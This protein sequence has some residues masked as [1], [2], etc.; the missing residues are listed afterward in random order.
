M[1]IVVKGDFVEIEFTGIAN[2][3]VFDT[4]NAEELKKVNPNAIPKKTIIAIG[5]GMVVAGLDF[6]LD[7]KEIG[8]EYDILIKSNDAFGPRKK[9]L[10]KV[11]PLKAFTEKEVYPQAGMVLTLD[12]MLVKIIAVSGARVTVDFNNP[13]AGKDLNYK[14]KI[15][16][17]VESDEEKSKAVFELMFRFVPEFSTGEKI[18]VK[19]PKIME[20]FVKAYGTKFKEIVGK[21]LTFE[22][23]ETKVDDEK[24]EENGE[25]GNAEEKSD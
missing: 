13:L 6:A 24:K 5:H 8:K 11:I 19:G 3:E 14:F 12:D 23:K 17:K 22:L 9:E 16:R 1:T 20:T 15:V 10:V 18:T 25:V 2:G 7:R 21:D 4:N